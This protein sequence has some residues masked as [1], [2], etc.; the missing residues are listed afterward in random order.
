MDIHI[1]WEGPYA[2]SEISDLNNGTRDYGIYQIYGYHPLYGQSVLLYIGQANQQTFATRLSQEGWINDCDFGN[3]Q[4][5]VGRL[6]AQK[7]V[8]PEEWEQRIHQAEKLLIYSHRPAYN[9]AN[10]KSIPEDYVLNNHIYNWGTHRSL[11]PEVSGKR[12]TSKYSHISERHIFT[13]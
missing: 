1:F 10:T 7:T 4:F 5:Y 2:L 9:T 3:L 12:H 6:A 13:A 11:F 8:S